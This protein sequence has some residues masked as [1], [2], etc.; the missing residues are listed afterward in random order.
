MEKNIVQANQWIDKCY[1][2]SVPSETT[3]KRWHANFKHSHPDTNDAEYSVVPKNSTNSFS[4][5]VN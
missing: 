5:I 1:S 2:D 3:V 4:P